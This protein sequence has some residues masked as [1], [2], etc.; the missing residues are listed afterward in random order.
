MDLSC[1][2]YSRDN[3]T[4]QKSVNLECTLYDKL[5][6]INYEYDASVSTL[7]NICIEKLV[8]TNNITYYPRPKGELIIYRSI[9]IR[10]DNLE[11]LKEINGEKGI[12]ICRLINLAIKRFL[13]EQGQL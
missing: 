6:D 3:Y 2:I 11:K 7:V 9:M 4:I 1:K 13:E 8:E 10:K 12:A 5:K